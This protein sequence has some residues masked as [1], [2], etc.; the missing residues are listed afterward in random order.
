MP[1]LGP[2]NDHGTIR[3]WATTNRAIPAEIL[4]HIVDGEP[5]I[6]RL[7]LAEQVA[8]NA[9]I[10]VISWDEFFLKFDSL[11][12]TFVYD[13]DS[14]GYNEILQAEENSPYRRDKDRPSI[15]TH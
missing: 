11:G 10:R 3:Y 14:T 6:L 9:H 15:I 8:C 4:P 2:T 5:A 12:L 13:D 1:I 7:M